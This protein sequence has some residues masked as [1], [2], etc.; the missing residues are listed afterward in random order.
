MRQL[1]EVHIGHFH[2]HAETTLPRRGSQQ[3]WLRT[4]HL[5]VAKVLQISEH[6]FLDVETLVF[7]VVSQPPDSNTMVFAVA[8][9][10][11]KHHGISA[12]KHPF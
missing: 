9:S 11:R 12:P 1:Q 8:T 5:F 7:A 6:P 2:Y 3:G 10:E 4:R